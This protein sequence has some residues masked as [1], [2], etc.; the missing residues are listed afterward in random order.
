MGFEIQRVW[1]QAQAG[2]VGSADQVELADAVLIEDLEQPGHEI[3]VGEV[4]M[5][6]E[7]GHIG[8]IWRHAFLQGMLVAHPFGERP[9]HLARRRARVVS[10][11]PGDRPGA[12]QQWPG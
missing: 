2:A 8:K 9:L 6:V 5:T 4:D 10:G 1:H 12:W 3:G 7:Q 11:R